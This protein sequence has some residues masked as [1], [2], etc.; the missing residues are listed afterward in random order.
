MIEIRLWNLIKIYAKLKLWKGGFFILKIS[1]THRI[2]WLFN[3][4]YTRISKMMNSVNRW[5]HSIANKTKMKQYNS[6]IVMIFFLFV[7]TGYTVYF[8]LPLH[9]HV[10]DITMVVTMFLYSSGSAAV[11]VPWGWGP[12]D[13]PGG[14]S[15]CREGGGGS[16]PPLYPLHPQWRSGRHQWPSQEWRRTAGGWFCPLLQYQTICFFAKIQSYLSMFYSGIMGYTIYP[17]F[18]RWS[19]LFILI[20]LYPV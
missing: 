12:G 16:T 15:G 11:K 9:P 10:V 19:N 2:D 14:D 1:W 18:S 6:M 7:I 13:Q 5:I 20:L 3:E 4:T 17:V 8:P